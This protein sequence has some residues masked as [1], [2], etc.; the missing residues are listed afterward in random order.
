MIS[1]IYYLFE[2]I[3]YYSIFAIGDFSIYHTSNLIYDISL[4]KNSKISKITPVPLKE[5]VIGNSISYTMIYLVYTQ[6]I[7]HLSFAD[8][9]FSNSI[10]APTLYL[11]SQ[12]FIFFVMHRL[13]HTPFLYKRFHYVHHKFRYPTS[14]AGRFS[15]IVDSNLENIAFTFPAFFIPINVYLWWCCLIF[16]FIW[17]NFLH[18]ST[19]KIS[20]KYINDNSDHCLHHY[21]GQKNYNFSYYFNHCDKF[22]GTYKKLTI[23]CNDDSDVV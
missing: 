13:A 2:F 15:H 3:F 6:K 14:W 1:N 7:G 16:S 18:D 9:N 12:D 22:F 4:K 17:G 20:I 11:L 5:W 19:N 10:L 21:Y 8:F 23:K